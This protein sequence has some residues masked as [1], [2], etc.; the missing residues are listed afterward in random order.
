MPTKTIIINNTLLFDFNKLYLKDLDNEYFINAKYPELQIKVEK[1]ENIKLN[2]IVKESKILLNENYHLAVNLS[3]YLVQLI[4][5]LIENNKV[6]P[7]YELDDFEIINNNIL[8]TNTDKIIDFKDLS[9]YNFEINKTSKIIFLSNNEISQLKNIEKTRNSTINLT[10]KSLSYVLLYI[11]NKN[12]ILK[13]GINILQAYKSLDI[14]SGTK[15]YYFLVL[16]S[17]LFN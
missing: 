16:I 14:I 5:Y 15:L 1:E 17:F 13:N 9:N 4:M 10:I 7:Y 12:I 11:L 3:N 6:I 8:F 2:S